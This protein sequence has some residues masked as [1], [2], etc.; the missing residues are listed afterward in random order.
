[1]TIS[2]LRERIAAGAIRSRNLAMVCLTIIA[3]LAFSSLKDPEN[4]IINVIVAISA[5]VNME[6]NKREADK[7]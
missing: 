1:M 7:K 6:G 3:T 4:I 5:M 2:G